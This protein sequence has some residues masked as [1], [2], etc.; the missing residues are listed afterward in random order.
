L[1]QKKSGMYVL[2]MFVG[3]QFPKDQQDDLDFFTFP[4]VDSTIGADAIEA[5][6]D[7][8]MMAKRPRNEAAAKA[9]LSYLGTPAAEGKYVA[10]DPTVIGVNTAAD[11]SGYSALQKKA[12][13]FVGSAKNISQ[14]MDRDTRPDFAS[15]VMIP[16]IQTFIKNPNDI[17]GL[18]NSIEKQKKSIFASDG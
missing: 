8:F 18:T 1:Q 2:G 14:F 12:V 16:A 3:Q 11:A 15:N 9:F 6:I 10:N 5:P 17:D 13:E 4:E 7:G